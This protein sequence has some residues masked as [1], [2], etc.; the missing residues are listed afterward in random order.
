MRIWTR[1]AL[2]AVVCLS[3]TC[4]REHHP[5][6]VMIIG[7]DTLRRDHLGCYGYE[8]DT[9]PNIDRL[10]AR[11]VLFEDAV[12]PS[13]W[14]L[15]SFVSA[16]TSLYPAQHEAGQLHNMET[17]SFGKRVSPSCP[18]LAM[19]LLKQGYSTGAVINAPALAPE[20]GLDRG[21]EFYSVTPGWDKRRADATTQEALNWID[22]TSGGPFF[23]FVHY[24]DPHLPYEPPAPYDTIFDPDY[25]GSVSVPFE[26]E[27]F[28]QMWDALSREDDPHTLRDWDHIRAIYDGEIRFTDEAVGD[29]LEGLDERG[30]RENTLIVFLSDHGE[31]FYDHRG[32]GHGHTLYDEII[33]V[34]L[35]F[36]LAGKLPES[37]RI[38]QQVRLLDLVPTI[39]DLLGIRPWT[40]LEGTSLRPLMV[41]TGDLDSGGSSLLPH[42][43]AYSEA[44]LYGT[45]KKSV[46]ARPWKLLYDTV[47]QEVMLFNLSNDPGEYTNLA[48]KEPETK[49]LLEEML[50]KTLLATSDTWYVEVAGGKQ[51]HVFDLQV[52]LLRE[53]ISGNFKLYKFL[54]SEGRI[55]D[56]SRMRL[57]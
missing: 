53:P 7:V 49:G 32:F 15:P 34:P 6:N 29:L 5:V 1:L 11:S 8:R 56:E 24:F 41:E 30:L 22:A 50:L 13:P 37:K 39:L 9:S 25:R 52:S 16:F 14:T 12:A 27:S 10:A 44:M 45:E 40:H 31:E 57:A 28:H 17:G 47:T 43:V 2:L 54:D 42:Q 19:M 26:R 36:S 48:D 3:I 35:T 46:T 18:S 33:K 51:A 21:F 20:L 23:I 55:V 4:G 38:S